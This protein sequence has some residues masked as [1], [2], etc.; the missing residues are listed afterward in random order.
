MK[1]GCRP[2]FFKGTGP[3]PCNANLEAILFS[4][5]PEHAD[6]C[7]QGKTSPRHKNSKSTTSI[8]LTSN[9]FHAELT[10]ISNC[11]REA[12]ESPH[13]RKHELKGFENNKSSAPTVKCKILQDVFLHTKLCHRQLSG[14]LSC[15]IVACIPC[16]CKALPW[17][18]VGA[19]SEPCQA[20]SNL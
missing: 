6:V 9:S 4:W 11:V 12:P 18:C 5:Q 1:L 20:Q 3:T 10:V 17:R 8:C 15:G 13:D 19:I 7:L 2:R 14:S 16:C